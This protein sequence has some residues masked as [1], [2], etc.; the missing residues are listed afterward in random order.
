MLTAAGVDD[1]LLD[2]EIPELHLYNLAGCF[3]GYDD[4]MDHLGLN[5]AEQ[6]D[7]RKTYV[8]KDSTQSAVAK[9]LRL[10]RQRDPSTATFRELLKIIQNLVGKALVV[11]DILDYIETL[12]AS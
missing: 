11:K 8:M 9:A 4:Y 12:P 10:W 2:T 5:R 3:D 1:Y 6:S 7:V